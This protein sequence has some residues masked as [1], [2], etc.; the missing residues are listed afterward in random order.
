MW[1]VLIFYEKMKPIVRRD[2]R[3]DDPALIESRKMKIQISSSSLISDLLK[4]GAKTPQWYLEDR[5]VLVFVFPLLD[6]WALR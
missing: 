2:G 4:S 1:C 5:I 3:T 6:Q